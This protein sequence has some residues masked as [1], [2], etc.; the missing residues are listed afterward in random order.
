MPP[1][2]N[3]RTGIQTGLTTRPAEAS[4]ADGGLWAGGAVDQRLQELMVVAGKDKRRD[5]K[6]TKKTKAELRTRRQKKRSKKEK[7]TSILGE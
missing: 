5:T 2:R 3:E 1:D 4:A 7:S 6:P